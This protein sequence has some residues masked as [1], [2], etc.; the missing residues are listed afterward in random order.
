MGRV[1][2]VGALVIAVV[3]VAVILMGGGSSYTLRANFVDAGGLVAGNQVLMGPATVGTI[4]SITLTPNS[5]AQVSMTMDSGVSPIPEGTTAR[6][7]ENS[8][9]GIANKYV[10]LNP[11]P[12]DA[13]PIPSGGLIPLQD[14][15]SFVSLDQIFDTLNPLTRAGLRNYIQG[16]AASI[17]GRA[18]EA[19]QT[20]QYF[21]PALA[22]TSDVTRE[23]TQSEPTFDSLLVQGAQAMQLLASRAQVLTQLVSNT[24]TTTGAIARESQSL[25]Q[26]L[27]LFPNT[28][29]Q[30]T[31][32]FKGLNSTLDVLTPL[33]QASK[34]GIRRLTP[35]ATQLNRLVGA[36]IPTIASLNNL[37][38]NPNGTGDLTTL[39]LST[40]SLERVASVAIPNLIK[41]MN[42]SQQQ[43]NALRE[44]A[45]DIVAALTNVGQSNG[46]YDA[47]GHYAR[48]QP[49]FNAFAVN[50]FNQL[51]TKPPS[52]RYSGLTV[53]HQ[54]CPGAAA[55]ATPDGS[56]PW[57][58]PGCNPSELPP[59]S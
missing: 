27:Q 5:L 53:V 41:Q 2:A 58:V 13:P 22:S 17:E 42:N 57:A 45:P 26:A 38:R 46:Y 28:L 44:Y 12:K 21:A 7:Y 59:G 11:G 6:I 14:T 1:A 29:N 49:V 25:Q 9:S 39:A 54:R 35:F 30:Q 10:V 31:Q 56:S 36:S 19:N 50:G 32:S 4:N 55:Q 8:L 3:V 40:P 52:Q 23:L 43:L 37:I 15:R 33:V 18:K 47:N 16:N 20:I 51:T 34:V 24:A 48:T